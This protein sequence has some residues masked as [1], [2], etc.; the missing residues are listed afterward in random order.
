MANHHRGEVDLI[1][2]GQTLTLCL[3]LGALAEIENAFGARDLVAL[4]ERL[5]EGRLAARDI[6]AI[7]GAAARGGGAKLSDQQ[8]GAMLNAADLPAAVAAIA[9]LF[10]AMFPAAEAKPDANP[11]GP[12]AP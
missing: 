11:P 3:T 10:A 7:I 5:G 12:Q 9:R 1:I 6:I 4:G 2:A 8:A